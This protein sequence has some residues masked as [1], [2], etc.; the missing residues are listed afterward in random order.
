ML[1][2]YK[3]CVPSCATSFYVVVSKASVKQCSAKNRSCVNHDVH[4]FLG[5]F[6]DTAVTSSML[7]AAAMYD[8]VHLA[9]VLED[10]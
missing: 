7:V 3:T 8:F 4:A 6:P 10:L 1:P 2:L 5:L 9:D